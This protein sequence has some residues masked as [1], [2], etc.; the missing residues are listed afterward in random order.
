MDGS[1]IHKL[2]LCLLN[3]ARHSAK[4]EQFAGLTD[5]TLGKLM[6]ISES[7]GGTVYPERIYEAE[8]Y[9]KADGAYVPTTSISGGELEVRISVQAVFGIE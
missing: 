3:C 7:G 8:A 9:L 6:Y 1:T 5:V 4:A 2:G